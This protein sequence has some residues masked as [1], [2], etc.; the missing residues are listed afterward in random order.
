MP[1]ILQDFP[2]NA[3]IDK[4]FAAISLPTGLDQWWTSRSAGQPRDGVDYE[5]SFGPEYDWRGTV[6]RSVPDSEFELQL[7]R[8]D[9]DWLGSRVG[10]RLEPRGDSTWVRFH[11]TGWP[12]ANEHYRISCHCWAMYLRVLR[13]WLEH[14]ETVPY[15]QRLDV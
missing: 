6:T 2:I 11:H 13:R 1:D 5:L 3:P 12:D 7:T 15:E 10:F 14:G 9:A 8:A 4:V